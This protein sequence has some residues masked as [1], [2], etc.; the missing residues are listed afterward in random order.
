MSFVDRK[1]SKDV[2]YLS[3]MENKLKSE[4]VTSIQSETSGVRSVEEIVKNSVSFINRNKKRIAL[5]ASLTGISS[6]WL[7]QGYNSGYI[8]AKELF[9]Q[10]WTK[11]RI[12]SAYQELNSVVIHD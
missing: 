10:G 2:K 12:E 4:I 9:E 8:G 5:V 6:V 1:I 7:Y 11:E 3:L